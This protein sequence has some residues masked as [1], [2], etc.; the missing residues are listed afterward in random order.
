MLSMQGVEATLHERGLGLL[1]LLQVIVGAYSA[2]RIFAVVG[3]IT[4]GYL[5]ERKHCVCAAWT[6]T[7]SDQQQ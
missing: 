7:R 2:A 5:G 6:R 1:C 4:L 3:P